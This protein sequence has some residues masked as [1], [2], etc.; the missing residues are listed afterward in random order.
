MTLCTETAG[1][2]S[3]TTLN[4]RPS[5]AQIRSSYLE[6]AQ[7][8]QAHRLLAAALGTE[9]GQTASSLVTPSFS[10]TLDGRS[11]TLD[12]RGL[13]ELSKEQ[14]QDF[15]IADIEFANANPML[16]LIHR[17]H[18]VS[19]E[20]PEPTKVNGSFS[21]PHRLL[22]LKHRWHALGEAP[23]KIASPY[24]QIITDTFVMDWG[25]GAVRSYAQLEDWLTNSASSMAAA[26]HDIE[27]F[28]WSVIDDGCFHAT[29]EFSWNGISKSGK[30]M[31]AQS[32]HLWLVHDNGQEPFGRI[33]RMD[34]EFL[35]P[36][37]VIDE[38]LR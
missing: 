34:V 27:R 29:F 9:T 17:A 36:F 6:Q 28:E 22:S 16:P 25:T 15:E 1:F 7:N 35:V 38:D 12:V 4:K 32:R 10:C 18:I 19:S 37:H 33:D 13:P 8:S 26:R 31:R 21:I 3:G 11:V 23:T 5:D 30:P 2:G 14:H 20:E 24:Q